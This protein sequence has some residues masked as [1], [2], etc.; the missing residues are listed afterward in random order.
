VVALARGALEVQAQE[1]AEAPA[2]RTWTHERCLVLRCDVR[3]NA[4]VETA[5]KKT[6]ERFGQLDIV[7][8][9]PI[10]YEGDSR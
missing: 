7:A 4:Q 8:K 9:Y 10:P 1:A 2:Q 3:L 5:V 6:I